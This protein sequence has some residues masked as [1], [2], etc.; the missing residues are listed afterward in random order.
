MNKTLQRIIS[1]VSVFMLATVIAFGQNTTGSI[2][3]TV[4]DAN[5]AVVPGASVTVSGVSVGFN[6][7]LTTNSDGFYRIDRVP[8]GSYKVTVA[9]IKGFAERSVDAFVNIEKTA[10]ADVTLSTEGIKTDVVVVSGDPLGINVDTS[11]SKVQTNITTELINKLPTGTSFSSLLKISPSTRFE[12]ITGGFSV[13]GASKAE[14]AFVIDGQDVTSYRYGTLGN[15]DT[16]VSTANIPT[17]LVKEVQVKTSGFEAEH[18]GASGGVIV[19]AT[20]SGTDELHGEFGSQFT[21]SKLQPKPRFTTQNLYDYT[22]I[23]TNQ[24]L[25]A[26]QAPQ[27][28]Y[29]E[30]DPTASLGGR[31]IKNHLWFYGIYSPQ[32]FSESSTLRYATIDSTT[33]AVTLDTTRNGSGVV[34]PKAPETY[35]GNSRYEY[36]QGRLDYSFFNKLSGFSSFLWNPF[37]RSGDTYGTLVING[38]TPT[39]YGYSQTGPDL[40]RL[41]GGRNNSNIINNQVSYTP[42]N[43]LAFSGRYGYGFENSK[44]DAYASTSGPIIQCAGVSSHPT[45]T[46]GTNQCPGGF[47]W[48]SSSSTGAVL[49]E[50]SKHKTIDV[51]GSVFFSAG[52]RHSLKAGY[53]WGQYFIDIDTTAKFNINTIQLY[54]GRDPQAFIPGILTPCFPAT[55]QGYG[56]YTVYREGGTGSNK[57]QALFVQDKWQYRRLTLNLGVRAESENLPAFNTAGGGGSPI[58]IPWGR[59]TTPRLGAAF[60]LFGDGKTRI[61]GSYGVFSDRLKFELP[62]GSFGGAFYTRDYFPILNS[63]PEFSYYTTAVIFGAFCQTCHGNGNPSTS[64]GLSQFHQDFRPDSTLPATLNGVNLVG[65]DP[66]LKPFKQQEISFGVETQLWNEYVLS[67]RYTNKRVLSTIEDIGYF[68]DQFYTIGNPGEGAA[69]TQ[70]QA[71]GYKG[72]AKPERVYNGVEVAFTK[73]FSRNYFFSANY[74]WS[75]LFGNYSGLANSDY[76]DGGSLSGNDASRSS[77]GVNRFFDW[78]VVGFSASG[79]P[80][81]GLLA[82]DRT[83]VVKAYGGYSFDW[84]KSKTN[85][86]MVSFFTTIQSGTPQ[87]TSVQVGSGTSVWIPLTKRGDL[88]RTEAYTQTDLTFSHSY[89]FGRDSRFKLVGDITLNNAFNENNVTAINPRRWIVDSLDETLIVPGFTG[90]DADYVRLENA[91]VAGQTAAAITAID[92]ASNRNAIY[93][94]PSAYQARRNIRFGFRMIF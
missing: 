8:S 5:G 35:V 38:T 21:T 29:L 27:R 4:K 22:G 80:D 91:I 6:Q 78:S 89:K 72:I 54:Y 61:Y 43:W 1:V 45:Y 47:G 84:F 86:T 55:C 7:T 50:V 26:V 34:I 68:E 9:P 93:K 69:L 51:D 71:A 67:A 39:Q 44:P 24:R 10:T 17:A 16:D 94:Q 31:I 62:I 14:N 83:H 11:D 90:S 58:S 36:A 81:N 40:A 63:H 59:K 3:G 15:N 41:K 82:T 20:K 53:G 23:S 73:R 19:V 77:P 85:E 57:T 64:G 12:G 37:I 2:E 49:K 56:R 33:A 25:F 42:T 92:T 76:W 28:N 88:G 70:H 13:E 60:D 52:G 48:T 30:F 75:R 79:G 74:T 66:N 87:T 65:V 18:G 32:M 46:G